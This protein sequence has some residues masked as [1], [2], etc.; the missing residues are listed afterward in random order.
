MSSNQYAAAGVDLQQAEDAKVRIGRMVAGTRT[1]LSVGEVGAFGGMLR[2]PIGMQSPVL[3]MSTDGENY[4]FC[5][6][7]ESLGNPPEAEHSG[8][9]EAISWFLPPHYSLLLIGEKDLPKFID[10]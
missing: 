7:L 9:A 8:I 4:D 1:A 5:F 10:L 3:V 6:S 2:L